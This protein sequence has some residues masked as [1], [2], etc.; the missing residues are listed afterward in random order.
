[1]IRVSWVIEGTG[2]DS[3]DA[4][5]VDRAAEAF[6]AGVRAATAHLAPD[7]QGTV[8][9]GVVGPLRTA[10]L[11][12]GRMAAGRGDVWQSSAG[13]IVVQMDPNA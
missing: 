4:P 13:G 6:T 7:V 9:Y 3:T 12:D 10:M 1:M 8:L 2:A 5:D 11:T